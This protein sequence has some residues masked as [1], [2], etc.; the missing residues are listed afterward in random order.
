MIERGIDPLE[1][2][3]YEEGS[4][5]I[6]GL[7]VE[8][9]RLV[10][11]TESGIKISRGC[12]SLLELERAYFHELLELFFN[13]AVQELGKLIEKVKPVAVKNQLKKDLARNL[14]KPAAMIVIES[15]LCSTVLMD[16]FSE[17][18]ARFDVEL[19]RTARRPQIAA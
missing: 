11:K 19:E 18:M 15:D 7:I 1:N 13:R 2:I 16:D 12:P 10:K 6:A 9:R 5:L 17:L 3:V 14:K 4:E 8:L